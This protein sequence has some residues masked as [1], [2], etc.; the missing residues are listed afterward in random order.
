MYPSEKAY[1]RM[2]ELLAAATWRQSIVLPSE[3]EL[4]DVL[5]VGRLAV[6]HSLDRLLREGMLER[7]SGGNRRYCIARRVGTGFIPPD[8]ILLP[9][10][11]ELVPRHQSMAGWSSH[12]FRSAHAELV[13]ADRQIQ[14]IA[15]DT[16]STEEAERLLA[17]SPA[18][19]LL[20]LPNGKIRPK[21]TAGLERLR[22]GL[23]AARA[24][25][26]VAAGPA[27]AGCDRVD[28]DHAAG[29]RLQAEAMLGLG[30]RRLVATLP[31][32]AVLWWAAE[33]WNGI[34]LAAQQAGAEATLVILHGGLPPPPCG[35]TREG[36]EFDARY[37]LGCLHPHAAC[38]R[39]F[40]AVLAASDAQ[41]AGLAIACERLGLKPGSKVRLAGYD[42]YWQDTW[43]QRFRPTVPDADV[44]KA[45]AAIGRTA[46]QLLLERIS[47][48]LPPGPVL[49]LVPPRLVIPNRG[50]VVRYVVDQ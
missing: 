46:A 40:D 26:V 31:D 37:M 5:A 14:R 12:L 36:L 17:M 3:R 48:H 7:E 43:Y 4:M 35:Q 33:R 11:P 50:H 34:R 38:N 22:D 15:L 8:A 42:N 44:D 9:A 27:V 19:L 10:G 41:L 39:S 6:R 24:A 29:G 30:C 16:F 13:R 1:H 2:R 32:P 20:L 28:S 23:L 18:G 21:A 49:R 47:G 45:N 25:V